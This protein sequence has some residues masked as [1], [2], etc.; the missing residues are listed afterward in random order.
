MD[1]ITVSSRNS[2]L[3]NFEP[4]FDP[5]LF[6]YKKQKRP[7]KFDSD[8]KKYVFITARVHPGETPGSH[9]FNGVLK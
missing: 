7:R 4:R 3:K 6:P 9:V 5:L 2:M 1:V 8:Q